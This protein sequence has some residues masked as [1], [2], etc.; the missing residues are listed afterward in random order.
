M[1]MASLNRREA[2]GAEDRTCHTLVLNNGSVEPILPPEDAD[3]LNNTVRFQRDNGN[4]HV[5]IV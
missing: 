3:P 1:G 4:P 2:R 5:H